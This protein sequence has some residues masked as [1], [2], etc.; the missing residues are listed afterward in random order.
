[1]P[2]TSQCVGA[3][4]IH[5]QE[6]DV[7]LSPHRSKRRASRR[8]ICGCRPSGGLQKISPA[9]SDQELSPRQSFAAA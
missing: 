8:Q 5:H 1:M 9:V 7:G 4:V 6:K 3:L 2:R